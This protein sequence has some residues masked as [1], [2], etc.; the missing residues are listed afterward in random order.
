MAFGISSEFNNTLNQL[1][2]IFNQLGGSSIKGGSYVN[3]IFNIT[4]SVEQI[5]NGDTNQQAAG[6]QNLVKEAMSLL[7]KLVNIQGKADKKVKEDAEN[8]EEVVD[9]AQKI[10]A[11]L[12]TALTKT[13]EQISAQTKIVNT[14]TETINEAQKEL[15]AKQEKINDI[16]E[17]IQEKQNELANAKTTNDQKELLQEISDLGVSI[18]NLTSDITTY[19]ETISG[20]AQNIENAV[21]EIET[22]KGNAVKIQENGELQITAATQEAVETTSDIAT[23]Q[24]D[25][26]KNITLGTALEGSTA[27]ES[28]V[29]VVGGVLAGNTAQKAAE[30]TA[31]GTKETTGS[32]GNLRTLLQGI[33]GIA[34]NTQLLATFKNA[35]GGALG[36]FNT[37]V[38]V[39]NTA[40]NPVITSIGSFTS[41]NGYIAQAENLS[42]VITGDYSRIE[43]AEQGAQTSN[44]NATEKKENS[45]NTNTTVAV[46]DLETPKFKFGI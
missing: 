26:V 36:N 10:E 6:V 2:G 28:V 42:Q 22:A 3:S 5:V 34:E 20:A 23:T 35:I 44:N 8:A 24:A 33:G 4:G 19:Q 9:E 1:Q 12:N 41:E 37:A 16:I 21:V 39:W 46:E 31:A 40:I 13:G 18:T 15:Q 43:K 38:D 11:E 30:L 29:P 32:V 45:Q 27:A 7:E 14:A 25:G 17:Q